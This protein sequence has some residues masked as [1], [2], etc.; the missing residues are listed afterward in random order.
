MDTALSALLGTLRGTTLAIMDA[1]GR[2]ELVSPALTE[3]LGLDHPPRD[4]AEL[5]EGQILLC[6][7][8]VTPA[9]HHELPGSRALRGEVVEDALLVTCDRGGLLRYQRASAAPIV[10][11]DTGAITGAVILVRDVTAE[12]RLAQTEE[13]LRHRLVDVINHQFR[14]PLTS[15]L[16]HGELLEDLGVELPAQARSSLDR[17]VSASRR[18][19]GLT[20]AV[21]ALVDLE[22]AGRLHP[23]DGDVVTAVRDSVAYLQPRAR[24]RRVELAVRL[25]ERFTAIADR[26]LLA[27]AVYELVDNAV[28]HSPPGGSVVVRCSAE[29]HTLALHVEDEGPGICPEERER[30]LHYFEIGAADTDGFSRRGLGLAFADTVAV[31]HGGSLRLDARVPRGLV[32]TL[33]IPRGTVGV[34]GKASSG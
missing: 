7:D 19:A 13:H 12:H 11:E 14:T 28:R 10:D 20:E 1:Q 6:E 2:F 31:A 33:A 4:Q 8:G 24:Q 9:T 18:L 26:R 29:H 5:I 17:I 3:Q 23:T 15:V 32:A 25:P 27:R 16:G 21:S 30:L 34:P 22:Q